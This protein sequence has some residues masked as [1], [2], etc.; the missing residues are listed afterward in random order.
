VTTRPE[1]REAVITV[2]DTGVGMDPATLE[3]AFVPFFT[4]RDTHVGT[5]LGLSVTQG[6]V[7]AHGGLIALTSES[8]VGTTVVIRLPLDSPASST[9]PP[10]DGPP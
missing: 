1:G 2:A 5:G 9:P 8:G 10:P 4:T 3:N 7:E 6:I